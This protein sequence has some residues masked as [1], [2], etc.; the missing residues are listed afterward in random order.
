MI[1]KGQPFLSL[2]LNQ[3]DLDVVQCFISTIQRNLPSISWL[4]QCFPEKAN[5]LYFQLLVFLWVRVV[6]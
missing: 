2:S 4:Y 5:I 3:K 6:L 1:S